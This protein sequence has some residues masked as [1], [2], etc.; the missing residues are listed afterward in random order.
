MQFEPKDVCCICLDKLSSGVTMELQCHHCVHTACGI[1]WLSKKRSCP[2]CR[3]VVAVRDP[4]VKIVEK[5]VPVY[6][7]RIVGPRGNTYATMNIKYR[8]K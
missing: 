8:Y 1:D 3:G 5:R 4:E 6:R 2:L 7:E